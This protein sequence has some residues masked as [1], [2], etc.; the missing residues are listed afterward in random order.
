VNIPPKL[1]PAEAVAE[2]PKHSRVFVGSA[3]GVPRALVAALVGRA[4]R[5][6]LE[7]ELVAGYLALDYFRSSIYIVSEVRHYSKP[8]IRE[9]PMSPS[10]SKALDTT[11]SRIP[12]VAVV[13]KEQV[14]NNG[15]STS[16]RAQVTANKRI[17][18]GF[19]A[20][21]CRPPRQPCLA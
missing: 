18:R 11:A 2:I 5:E 1:T 10:W 16:S 6:H 21:P 9:P 15:S 3:T 19:C 20:A 13:S 7:L 12:L 4:R 14:V 8:V 17:Q